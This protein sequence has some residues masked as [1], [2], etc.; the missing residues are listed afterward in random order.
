MHDKYQCDTF[1]IEKL[2]YSKKNLI[3]SFCTLCSRILFAVSN[4]A[5]NGKF[6]IRDTSQAEGQRVGP[7]S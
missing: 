7:M 1:T 3:K 4:L 5:Q 6:Q 2:H